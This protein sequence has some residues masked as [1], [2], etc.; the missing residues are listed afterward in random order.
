MFL[1]TTVD[2]IK[3]KLLNLFTKFFNLIELL[4]YFFIETFEF[5]L[6]ICTIFALFFKRS[7]PYLKYLSNSPKSLTTS[8]GTNTY[9]LSD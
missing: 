2:H 9:N 6:K 1:S 3:Q 5:L 7:I 4:V 8:T